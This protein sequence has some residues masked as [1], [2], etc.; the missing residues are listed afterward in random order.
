MEPALRQSFTQGPLV[1]ERV[2]TLH[3]R[4]RDPVVDVEDDEN[5]TGGWGGE[6]EEEED[7]HEDNGGYAHLAL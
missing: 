3:L 1:G 7:D 4:H 6:E 5:V 2:E